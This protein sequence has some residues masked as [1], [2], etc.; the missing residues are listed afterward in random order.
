MEVATVAQVQM[1]EE[2]RI[3]LVLMME[4]S[5]VQAEL[6]VQCDHIR[7]MR[8]EKNHLSRVINALNHQILANRGTHIDTIDLEVQ[9][10]NA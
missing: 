8:K 7:N 2:T 1:D 3:L 4:S 10:E 6:G 9:R 5:N